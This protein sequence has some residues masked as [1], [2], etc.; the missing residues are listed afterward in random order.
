MIASTLCGALEGTAASPS[1]LSDARF[2]TWLVLS[3]P[4]LRGVVVIAV[5]VAGLDLWI[6]RSAKVEGGFQGIPNTPLDHKLVELVG[7]DAVPRR[8]Y[9][10]GKVGYRPGIRLGIRDLGGYEGDP[11]ALQRFQRVLDAVKRAPRL[12]AHAGIKYV[13]DANKPQLTGPGLRPLDQAGMAEVLDP[14]ADVVWF[15]VAEVAP[16]AAKALERTLAAPPGTIA[17][18]EAGQLD[19]SLRARLAKVDAPGAVPVAGR[20]TSLE[21]RHLRAEIDA[22][23]DGLVMIDELYY[24]R[25]WTAEVDGVETPIVAVNGW[26]RGV[27]VGPGHHVI[28]MT[29]HATRFLLGAVI[30][31]LGWLAS[32]AFVIVRWRR[33]RAAPA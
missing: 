25:G 26:A 14:I 19:A 16:D 30:A 18:V 5:A 33:G 11:L 27:A 21:L 29:F 13:L 6:A 7:H 31:L 8:I 3:Y 2:T 1:G 24:A 15:D 12:A 20:L 32:L 4:K 9:D 17:V 22:P 10:D 28:E 23:A